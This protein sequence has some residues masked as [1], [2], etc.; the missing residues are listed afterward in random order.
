MV[1]G[2]K[3]AMIRLDQFATG[4]T[5]GI[6][7][8]IKG[9]K[10]DGATAIVFDLRGN[11]GGYVNEAVGVA[12]QFVGDGTVYQSVDAQRRREGRAGPA[13]WP[14]HRASRSSS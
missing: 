4:A 6:E 12:S 8:A 9:A 13:G 7:D 5:Q 14:R 2:R 3:V 1:P 10:A 11:P